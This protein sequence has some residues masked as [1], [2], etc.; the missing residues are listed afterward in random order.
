[1]IKRDRCRGALIGLA[2]G[3]ALG[4]AVEFM[5]PGSFAPV[6]G[7]RSGGPHRLNAGEWTDDTSMALALAD[8]IKSKGWDLN[9]QAGRYVDWW[10]NGKYSVNGRCFD[11]GITT[12]TALRRFIEHGDARSS[13][14]TDDRSSGN[15]CIM[16]IAPVAIRY[17]HL[18]T[19]DASRLSTLA[20]ES[21]LPTHSSSI[22]LSASS[23]MTML[24]AAFINGESRDTV[25]TDDWFQ[26]E[27]H[28]AVRPVA[29]GSFKRKKP[30]EI[31]ASG[32][33][34]AS[35]E[36]ALW[37]FHNA[38]SFEEAVLKAVNLGY[39]A[40]TSGAICGQLAGAFWG[41]NAILA[42]FRHGLARPDMIEEALDGLV[43]DGR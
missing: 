34:V 21:S 19:E 28:P 27:L 11:I 20:A 8:S 37:A 10:Q 22:C 23:Y 12:V 17:H 24:L 39:D 41:E 3:D 1:M 9:D 32:Y 18:F 13:G 31:E 15:G 33:V 4:A 7:Y 2:I 36:A 5:P 29:R 25:L 43:S 14:P 40:D 26:A 42:S 38:A 16:R 35:L 30:P 6:T